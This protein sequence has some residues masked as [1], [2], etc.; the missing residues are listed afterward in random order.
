[1]KK[2]TCFLLL[3]ISPLVVATPLPEVPLD[4][5]LKINASEIK[6]ES[7][8]EQKVIKQEKYVIFDSI[9]VIYRDLTQKH[10][11]ETTHESAEFAATI[12][13]NTGSNLGLIIKG[14]YGRL[15]LKR[16]IG[17]ENLGEE[18]GQFDYN[19]ETGEIQFDRYNTEQAIG[20]LYFRAFYEDLKGTYHL[21][22]LQ[23]CGSSDTKSGL[24]CV[25]TQMNRYHCS[26]ESFDFKMTTICEE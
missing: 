13:E 18:L 21:D 2:L 9:D 15:V 6:F 26:I 7:T 20:K 19:K 8:V 17:K 11:V 16:G 14:N 3:F 24:N 5:T 22:Q 25:P 12:D 23:L 4:Y 1:M 10:I